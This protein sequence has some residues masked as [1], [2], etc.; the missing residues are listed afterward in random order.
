MVVLLSLLIKGCGNQNNDPQKIYIPY[1]AGESPSPT[2]PPPSDPSCA[3]K[4]YFST[5]IKPIIER[6]CL[7]CHSAPEPYNSVQI[8]KG[9]IGEFTRRINLPS[10]NRQRMPLAPASELS[11]QEKQ[12]FSKWKAD[13]LLFDKE[14]CKSNQTSNDTETIDLNY[15]ETKILEDLNQIESLDR[16]QVRYLVL[17]GNKNS[18]EDV[19]LLLQGVN[20]GLNSVSKDDTLTKVSVIDEKKTLLR[21]DLRSYG[22]LKNDWAIIEAVEP[23]NFESFTN[24]GQIIKFLVNTRKPWLHADNFTFAAHG[25]YGAT[26]YYNLLLVPPTIDLFFK[27]LGVNSDQQFKDFTASLAGG[28]GSP[29]SLNKNRVISRNQSRD[30]YLWFSFDSILQD[31]GIPLLRKNFFNFPLP[32]KVGTG[33]ADFQFDA[34]EAIFT[35][36]NKL[37]GYALYDSA[38]K[39][40]DFAPLNIVA[41]YETPFEPTIR[42]GFSCSR[43]HNQGIIPMRDQIRSHILQNASQFDARDADIV[44]GLY[45]SATSNAAIYTSDSNLFRK[46]LVGLGIDLDLEKDPQS[47]LMDSLRRDKGSK[48]VAAFLFLTE[49][50]FL[51]RLNRSAEG[52]TQIGQLLTPGGTIS[53]QQF[54]D[55]L[56]VLRRDFRLGF[57]A[58]DQ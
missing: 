58:I 36:A 22:L 18:G 23:V 9:K 49:D 43:C 45:R 52:K 29:L 19:D 24:K 54:I 2:T 53:F 33:K 41:D 13:G 27:N 14:D 10:D 7:G 1:P 20:K 12:K 34:G 3:N 28:F 46:A 15:I 47:S 55:V 5:D 48:D 11:P 21:F 51:A 4:V 26:V 35:L 16:A 44:S 38:G 6:S 56:P 17:S 25:G 50:D 42:A 40:Q 32:P 57:D 39:R 31:P 8:A 37:Q 30:G